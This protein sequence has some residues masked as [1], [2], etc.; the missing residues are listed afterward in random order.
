MT[1]LSRCCVL[2]LQGQELQQQ[3]CPSCPYSVES[4]SYS[5]S[6]ALEGMFAQQSEQSAK[7]VL[8]LTEKGHIYRLSLNSRTPA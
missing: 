1:R 2:R 4:S 6:R 5:F 3:A 8:R 7:V